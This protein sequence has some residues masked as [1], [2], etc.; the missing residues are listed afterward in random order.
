[1]N[2]HSAMVLKPASSATAPNPWL[3][4]GLSFFLPGAGQ[5]FNGRFWKGLLLLTLSFLALPVVSLSLVYLG[6]YA[7]A[8]IFFPMLAPWAYSMINAAREAIRLERALA[9]FDSKR[10]AIYVTI[11]LVVAFPLVATVFST[12]TLLL[13][14]VEILTRIADW[15][16]AFRRA[17][18]MG[19]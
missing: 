7:S 8:A 14:P 5:A 11:L 10:G 12:I 15:S 17:I 16:E 3:A 9:E 18:G 19:G 1:M 4:A 6:G 13:L 2:V